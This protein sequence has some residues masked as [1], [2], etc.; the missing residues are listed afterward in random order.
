MQLPTYTQIV[1]HIPTI[2][3]SNVPG[4]RLMKQAAVAAIFRHQP[5]LPSQTELLFI[6]RATNPNDPW[7]GHMAFPGGR[8]DPIDNN[9]FDAA[10]RETHEEIG[11]D[12]HTHATHIGRL[13]QLIA[14]RKGR[15][16][17]LVIEPHLFT[18][19]APPTFTLNHEVSEVIWIPMGFF[20]QQENRSTMPYKIAGVEVTLPCYR[21][22]ERVIWGL[23]LRMLDELLTTLPHTN[24]SPQ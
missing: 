5:T 12:L 1:Q 15:P 13:S 7:S 16:L 19:E 21:Y 9:P 6:K 17:P 10:V 23:T 14:K 4:H 8:V 22:Q 2:K 18:L 20:L 11:L 3:T 24:P